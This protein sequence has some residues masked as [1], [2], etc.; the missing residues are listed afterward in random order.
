LIIEYRWAED[1]YDRLPALVAE[2]VSQRVSVIAIP[3]D[4]SIK[5]VLR[6]F[7]WATVAAAQPALMR[8]GFRCRRRCRGKCWPARI[9][10]AS[11]QLV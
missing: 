1:Q 9:T 10:P 7:A 2:L 4:V 3:G 11:G 6:M 8:D 5:T